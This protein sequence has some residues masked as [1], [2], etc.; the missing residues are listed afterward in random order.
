VPMGTFTDAGLRTHELFRGEARAAR[1][2]GRRY[3][4]LSLAAFIAVVGAGVALR[5]SAV[6]QEAFVEDM[7]A[8]Y[9]QTTAQGQRYFR[10]LVEKVRF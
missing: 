7:L 10:G 2:R 3:I 6:G 1:R 8:K 9:H 4:A 5:V